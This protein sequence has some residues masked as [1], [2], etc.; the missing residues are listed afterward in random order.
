MSHGFPRL[1]LLLAQIEVY[2]DEEFRNVIKF[3]IEQW[4]NDN[5]YRFMNPKLLSIF[6][7]L[8]GDIEEV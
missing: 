8:S 4:Q 3:Q 1:S 5:S 7:L 2:K 6:S